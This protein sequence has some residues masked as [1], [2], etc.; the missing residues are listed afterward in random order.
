MI[1]YRIARVT[2]LDGTASPLPSSVMRH[3]EEKKQEDAQRESLAAYMLLRA[4]GEENGIPDLLDRLSFENGFPVAE[5]VFVSLSH[6]GGLIAAALSTSPVGIDVE[7]IR[8]LLR[9]DALSLRYFYEEERRID[10]HSSE[11]EKDRRFFLTFTK[12]EAYAKAYR[13]PLAAV[14]KRDLSAYRPYVHEVASCGDLSYAVA[15]VIHEKTEM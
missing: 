3:V 4:L 14:M 1:A 11:D 8:P 2:D 6:A 7:P 10:D 9:R 13:L 12:K 15:V 5:D